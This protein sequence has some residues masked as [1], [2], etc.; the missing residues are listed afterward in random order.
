MGDGLVASDQACAARAKLAGPGQTAGSGRRAPPANVGGRRRIGSAP[1][2]FG[3]AAS[4]QACVVC[5]GL[6]KAG[7]D[8]RDRL[9]GAWQLAARGAR[10]WP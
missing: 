6:G 10:G 9:A 8:N 2:V 1:M 5:A 7:P 3:L 4:D